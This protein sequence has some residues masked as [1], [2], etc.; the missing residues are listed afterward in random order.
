MTS[1][2]TKL[3][4]LSRNENG[5]TVYSIPAAAQVN[6]IL[7]DFGSYIDILP[8]LLAYAKEKGKVYPTV[9]TFPL[10]QTDIDRIKSAY[11]SAKKLPY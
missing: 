9:K 1:I 5:K 3:Q 10:Q 7:T 11:H 2:F 6:N 4:A 8:N